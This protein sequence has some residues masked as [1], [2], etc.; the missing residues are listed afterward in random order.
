MQGVIPVLVSVVILSEPHIIYYN[1]NNMGVDGCET[2]CGGELFNTAAVCCG[3]S[4]S[5][6]RCWKPVGN[7]WR[8]RCLSTRLRRLDRE[9]GVLHSRAA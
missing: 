9:E 4:G 3:V 5:V 6:I 8:M 7:V 2:D 1:D